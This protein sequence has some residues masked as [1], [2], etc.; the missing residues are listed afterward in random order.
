LLLFTVAHARE[1]QFLDFREP[2]GTNLLATRAGLEP[3][4]PPT[5]SLASSPIGPR[6]GGT[7]W[8]TA[9]GLPPGHETAHKYQSGRIN[10][11]ERHRA[12]IRW[13]G[14][15][16]SRGDRATTSRLNL[17]WTVRGPRR[18][19]W[20]SIGAGRALFLS[21]R[22][23]EPLRRKTRSQ[24]QLGWTIGRHGRALSSP[25]VRPAAPSTTGLP[26]RTARGRWA[27]HRIRRALG[28]AD[29]QPS[30]DR[31][32]RLPPAWLEARPRYE[33]LHMVHGR[34]GLCRCCPP[35]PTR[36]PCSPKARR[37]GS[38]RRARAV[39]TASFSAGTGLL[40][41]ESDHRRLRTETVIQQLPRPRGASNSGW[42]GPC[43]LHLAV[44][45]RVLQTNAEPRARA[46]CTSSTSAS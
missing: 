42:F 41:D 34:S 45:V 28:G 11:G 46:F 13:A 6:G 23:H 38:R 14:V 39:G 3:G 33:A 20:E 1:S 32:D 43:H 22:W 12:G 10:P 40:Y 35:R 25:V 19:A 15:V 8:L 5:S 29:R 9:L 44:V 16:S 17:R 18:P 26:L 2:F 21:L 4:A 24:P 7:W 27:I 30:G 36:R 31:H 37:G